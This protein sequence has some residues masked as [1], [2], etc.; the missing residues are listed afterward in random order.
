M[1]EVSAR[2]GG[3][4]GRKYRLERVLGVGGMGAV[5][6]AVHRNGSA[7]RREEVLHRAYATS[8]DILRRFVREGLL[9]NRIAHEGVVRIVDDDRAEDGSVYLVM[10]LLDGATCRELADQQGGRLTA[11]DALAVTR[12]VLRVLE[13]TH[14]AGIVHR[15]IKPNNVFVTRAGEV[16]LLDFGI[17]RLMDRTVPLDAV[18]RTGVAL[19]TPGFMCPEQVLGRTADI[20]ARSDVW[21]VGAT[22]FNL[23]SGEHVHLGTAQEIAVFTATRPPRVLREVAGAPAALSN[24]VD[25]ALAL[26]PE[27]RWPSARAMLDALELTYRELYDDDLAEARIV[28]PAALSRPRPILAPRDS[29]PTGGVVTIDPPPGRSGAPEGTSAVAWAPTVLATPRPQDAAT[30]LPFHRSGRGRWAFIGL[31]AARRSP[32]SPAWGCGRGGAR[33]RALS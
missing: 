5:Y 23:L 4:L 24:L 32:W 25:R 19:G 9:A 8:E 27:A 1:A 22:V 3:V 29:A 15:D 14:R 12:D 6:E 21:A 33:G 2:L 26:A 7:R 11:R 10:E 20:D 13:V 17:A 18:T 28:A 30:P 16:K 31:F